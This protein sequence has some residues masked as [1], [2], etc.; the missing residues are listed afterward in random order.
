MLASTFRHPV[1]TGLIAI[2]LSVQPFQGVRREHEK[3]REDWRTATS[4]VLANAQ[5]GDVVL[6]L[7]EYASAPIEIYQLLA[8]DDT[9]RRT[10]ALIFRRAGNL[11]ADEQSN[12][13][14]IWLIAS[15]YPGDM[16]VEAVI[17]RLTEKRVAGD[18]ALFTGIRVIR[19][20]RESR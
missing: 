19:Y 15:A 16:S 1:F 7:P 10:L 5:P 2:A 8:L 9:H 11:D 13:Q 4:H 17:T 6:T 20:D 12:A 14:H 18:D 3:E